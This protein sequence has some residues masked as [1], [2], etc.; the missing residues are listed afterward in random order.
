MLRAA[1]DELAAALDEL[2]DLARGIHPA[3]L[4][5]HGLGAALEALAARVP[6]PVDIDR[7]VAERLPEPVEVAAYYVVSEAL[8]NVQKYAD[9]SSVRIGVG[10][11]N[12]QAVVEVH[13]DGVGGAD[14]TSGSG[15][16]GLA[17]RVEALGGRL[18][19]E[20]AAGAGTTV[21]ARIP[22]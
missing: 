14:A 4:S 7:A 16:R 8:A 9:A 22:V 18:E 21:R 3:V 12:G 15:L 6:L 10:R 2:R 13:D 11:E 1:R 5:D 17:D 20:S 19:V